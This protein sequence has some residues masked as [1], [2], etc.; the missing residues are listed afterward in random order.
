[1]KRMRIM[2]A[3]VLLLMTTTMSFAQSK[4]YFTN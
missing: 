3:A 4:V 1:M 2:A